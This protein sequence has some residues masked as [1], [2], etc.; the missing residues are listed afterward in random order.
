MLVAPVAC[1]VKQALPAEQGE[2][3][4]LLVMIGALGLAPMPVGLLG[5]KD[6]SGS[7]TFAPLEA[8]MAVCLTGVVVARLPVQLTVTATRLRSSGWVSGFDA[9]AAWPPSQ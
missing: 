6:C 7:P 3:V 9:D 8:R 5:A 1:A 4:E 2:N